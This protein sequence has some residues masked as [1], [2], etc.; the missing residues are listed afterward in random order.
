MT[1]TRETEPVQN[2]SEPL[3][4]TNGLT[5]INAT[6]L[7]RNLI[8]ELSQNSQNSTPHLMPDSLTYQTY[9][10]LPQLPNPDGTPRTVQNHQPLAI[11]RASCRERG[12][13]YV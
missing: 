12:C 5:C 8:G 11:G 6:E 7:D 3:K 2:S 1:H 13:Q 9:A 4:A 10:E